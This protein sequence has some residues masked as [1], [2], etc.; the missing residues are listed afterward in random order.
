MSP[1]LRV[2]TKGSF[3]TW[4]AA[5]PWTAYLRRVVVRAV[6]LLVALTTLGLAATRV[7]GPEVKNT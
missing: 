7:G 1:F 2:F 3:R 4:E 5:C 6:A